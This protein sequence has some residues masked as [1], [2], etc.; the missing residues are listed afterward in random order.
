MFSSNART[1]DYVYLL[2]VYY[3]GGREGWVLSMSMTVE[4]AKKQLA[5]IE[6]KLKEYSALAQRKQMLEH[7]INLGD[8]LSAPLSK[9]S[10]NQAQTISITTPETSIAARDVLRKSGALHLR[11]L[12]S[13]MQQMGWVGSS[14]Q[15]RA[16]KAVYVNMLRNKAVFENTGQN[17]WRIRTQ[18]TKAVS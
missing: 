16:E 13:K 15:K 10:V 3:T 6:M 14:D 2:Y 9:T 17:I 18:E 5:E 12:V 8:K 4:E 11:D 7:F 1:L